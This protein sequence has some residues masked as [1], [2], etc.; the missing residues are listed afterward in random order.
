MAGLLYPAYQKF[1]SSLSS[2]ERFDKEGNFFNNISCLDAFFSEY[3]NITFVIQAAL[4]HT[5]YFNIYEKNRDLYLIDHWFVEKRN[6]TIKQKPFQLVKELEVTV[7]SSYHGFSIL[8][9]SF[10]VENDT[11][12]ESIFDRLKTFFAQFSDDEIFFSASFYFHETNS[13]IDL[14][15]KLLSGIGSM[16]RFMNAMDKDIGEHCPLCEQ[17]KENIK[18]IKIATVP[19]DFLLVNDYIYYPKKEYFERGARF[20]FSMYLGNK[21]TMQRL[22]ISTLTQVEHLNYDGTPFGNFTFMHAILRAL[23]PGT[24]IMPAIM[25]IYEDKT[26]DLDVFHADI[27]TTVYRK[28]NEVAKM[29]EVENIVEVCYMGLYAVL[30]GEDAPATSK[31]RLELA[32]ND[33]LVCASID[34]NLNEKEYVFDGKEMENPEYVM[35]V[36]KNGH[37]DKLNASRNNMFPIWRAFNNKNQKK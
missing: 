25:V 7:Y 33:I 12:L 20:A 21:K 23:K 1:Y 35:C 19:K 29:I 31:E 37:S 24:D 5:E 28:I 30:I 15:D 3:R 2:L 34:N 4:K 36:M 11:P 13:D 18:K 27:K 16:H 26:Y 6:Q 22:P 14:F 32:T 9:E 8:N 10:S 17:L